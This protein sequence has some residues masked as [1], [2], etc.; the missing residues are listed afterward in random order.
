MLKRGE[1]LVT[2]QEDEYGFQV[3]A[4][5]EQGY[6]RMRNNIVSLVSDL[7]HPDTS[8]AQQ[9]AAHLTMLLAQ[10]AEEVLNI[11]TGYGITAGTFTLFPSVRAIET[12]EPGR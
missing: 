7:G 1:T 9:M 4:R 11:G 5:T 6:L 2:A 8:H 12:V 10:R 3:L